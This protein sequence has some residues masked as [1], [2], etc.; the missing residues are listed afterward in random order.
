MKILYGVQGTGN[1]HISRARAM[2]PA[3]AERDIAVD[4]L[5]SGRDPH[6]FFNMEP[7]VG[8]RCREGLTFASKNGS[9]SYLRT[10]FSNR[11]L[12]FLKDVW[13][14]DIS[15]YDLIVTDFE[16]VTAW[17]GKLRGL[18]VISMGHQPAFD[19]PVPTV[20]KDF[21]T[22][23]VM[24]LFAPGNVRL[25][26]HWDSFASPLLPPLVVQTDASV[27]KAPGKVLVY[28]PFEDQAHVQ[29]VLE[30]IPGWDFYVYASGSEHAER[31][32]LHL[33]PTSLEGFHRDL[34]DCSAVIC[35]AGFELS[36]ECLSLGKRLL[37]KPL[38]R[39]MEQLS[40]ARALEQLGYGSAME[41]LDSRHIQQWLASDEEPVLLRI[42][43]VADELA[44]WIAG[45]DY[46]RR[47]VQSLSARLWSEVEAL[48]GIGET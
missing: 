3:L 35:N 7:F 43:D 46:S 10:A 26:M 32:R 8:F 33:R 21:L 14:L 31:G 24:R 36:S 18:P 12:R 17:A 1:G 37:V 20:G 47:S 48:R 4:W 13:Q 41:Q 6:K 28:L 19:Y 29:Q 23:L 5:F 27:P 45:G 2:A 9:V 44:R 42:P 38:L 22:S 39:Q 25:G 30:A 34:A 40:N 15:A 16:P 11:Y